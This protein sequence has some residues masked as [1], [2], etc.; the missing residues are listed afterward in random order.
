MK[1]DRSAAEVR[2]VVS[3]GQT[4]VDR[5]ALD[6]AIALGLDHGGWCPKGR[7]AEDGAIPPR[8]RMSETTSRDYEVR[9]ESNVASSGGTLILYRRGL[10][11]GTELTYRLALRHDKPHLLVDLEQDSDP[12]LAREWIGKH[13]IEVLNVAGPRESTEPGIEL[14]ARRFVYA[15]LSHRDQR[16]SQGKPLGA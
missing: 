15:V 10:S 12:R 8:Y 4:G 7:L 2:L 6:A 3:G 16:A 13:K 14:A 11:G 1:A 5:G 9:T